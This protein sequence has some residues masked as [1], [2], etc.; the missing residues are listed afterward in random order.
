ML[1]ARQIFAANPNKS[2]EVQKFLIMNK[3]RLL[4]FLPKFLEDRTD[5]EQFNDEKQWLVKA[6]GNLPDS[7]SALRLPDG[8]LPHMTATHL[9]E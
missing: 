9:V 6:I 3:Q 1:T 2:Y 4:K 7:T 5:D 8:S